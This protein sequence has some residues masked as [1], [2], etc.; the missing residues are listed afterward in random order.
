MST[1]CIV[2]TVSRTMVPFPGSI[3]SLFFDTTSRKCRRANCTW[4][5][6]IWRSRRGFLSWF[7]VVAVLSRGVRGDEGEAARV[8]AALP[9][10][11]VLPPGERICDNFSRKSSLKERARRASFP[12]RAFPPDLSSTSENKFKFILNLIIY[13]K[14]SLHSFKILLTLNYN[15]I[16]I[17]FPLLYKYF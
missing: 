5:T 3:S 13:I 10:P 14:I 15:I 8:A 12:P 9:P 7:S 11:P 16:Q 4:R 1:V 17:I 6:C 2:V